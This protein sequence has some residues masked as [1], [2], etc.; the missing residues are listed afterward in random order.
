MRMR[1]L[2]ALALLLLGVV[3]C[4]SSGDA[5]PG[6]VGFTKVELPAGS[7]PV[8]LAVSGDAL[9]IGLRREGQALVP[10]VLRRGADGT[11]TELALRAAT[12]Y[13]KLA[14]WYSIASDG[15][16]IVAIG[17]ARGGA[18]GNVRW[19]AWTGSASGLSEQEQTFNTFGGNGAGDLIDAVLTGSGPVLVGTR[20]S[21]KTGLDA[22][23][24]THSGDSWNRQSSAGTPLESRPDSL[25]FPIAATA[26]GQ[27]PLITGWQLNSGGPSRQ[28]PVVWRSTSLGG[29]W[30]VTALPEPG[31][32]GAGMALRCWAASCAVAGRV[33]GKLALWRLDG[34]SWT[35]M[36]GVPP[37]PV[38]DKDR[39]AAPVQPDGRLTQILADSGQ[40]K[41]A[42][43]DGG[44]GWTV[45]AA[46][47]PT[48]TVTATAQTGDTIFVLAGPDED[49]LALWRAPTSA[50]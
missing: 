50:L 26:L 4:G 10:G 14:R 42:R 41:I 11:T 15:Q 47:G 40:V 18:H 9:L 23:V 27:G 24:W 13:G 36:P 19:S 20:Q 39:L 37:V 8:A 3:G 25:S 33:D 17:G 32:T 44:G 7:E 29:T 46:S 2:L 35:R 12:P 43:A 31:R 22:A 45:R 5:G 38:G 21:D 30:T 1:S 49:H 48:G 28:P 16:Q 34:E 6:A